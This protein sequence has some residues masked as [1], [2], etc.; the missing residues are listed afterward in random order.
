MTYSDRDRSV[1]ALYEQLVELE[2]RLVPTGLHVFG[3]PAE[4][5]DKADLLRMVA[6][7]DRPE[8]GARSLTKLVAEGLGLVRHNEAIIEGTNESSELIAAVTRKAVDL[9]CKEGSGAAADW[10]FCRSI[11]RWK[12]RAQHLICW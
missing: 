12:N 6:S 3:T 10:L 7:F 1:T 11:S 9:F 2:E 4:L 5:A 8:Y